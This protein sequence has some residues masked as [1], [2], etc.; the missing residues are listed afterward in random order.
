MTP[1]EIVNYAQRAVA[2]YYV[3]RVTQFSKGEGW[4]RDLVQDVCL[5]ILKALRSFDPSRGVPEGAFVAMRA[6]QSVIDSVRVR[7]GDTRRRVGPKPRLRFLAEEPLSR[8]ESPFEVASRAEDVERVRGAM[9]RI[10]RTLS[11]P[12]P[13]SSSPRAVSN[14]IAYRAARV[15]ER[16]AVELAAGGS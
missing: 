1:E 2:R 14:A 13:R 8:E 15:R 10:D 9:A 12:K 11:T 3:P 5:G 6:Q 16:I 4:K 7:L